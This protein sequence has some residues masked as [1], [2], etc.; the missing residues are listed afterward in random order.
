MS[1]LTLPNPFASSAQRKDGVVAHARHADPVAAVRG[2]RAGHVR[3]VPVLVGGVVVAVHVVVA[4]QEVRGEVGVRRVHARVEHGHDRAAADARVPRLGHVRVRVRG[5]GH[6]ADRLARVEQ[7]PELREVRVVRHERGM[8]DRVR[9]GVQD[10]RVALERSLRHR[11]RLP[12]I[13]R[14][15]L[16]PLQGQRVLEVGARVFTRVEAAGRGR[17]VVET[18]DQLPGRIRRHCHAH[19]PAISASRTVTRKPIPKRGRTASA[20]T[21]G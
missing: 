2:D 16:H 14:H 20:E 21:T 4:R 19:G 18:D 11:D 15:E 7:R 1:V 8:P 6:P 3:A 17:V 5:T 13:D 9:L 10:V 12:R